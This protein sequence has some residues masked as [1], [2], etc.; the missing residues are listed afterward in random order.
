MKNV[1]FALLVLCVCGFG[2]ARFYL[3]KFIDARVHDRI[4]NA[5][6]DLRKQNEQLSE[7]VK[8]L[9]TR[10]HKLENL[11]SEHK[12]ISSFKVDFDRWNCWCD[13]K[14]KLIQGDEYSEELAKFRKMFS[15]C[16]NL[17]KM[18][19]SVIEN[20]SNSAKDNSLINNLLRFAKIH[21][22]N[23]NE[24]DKITGY[25]LLLSI[26]KVEANE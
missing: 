4:S 8:N 12:V 9:E 7:T 13:L 14:N 16:P 19:N 6:A 22:I 5:T 20:G 3:P 10:L 1:V 24:L 18:L 17:L 15:D 23:G 2:G 11:P 21:G 25:V 26:R